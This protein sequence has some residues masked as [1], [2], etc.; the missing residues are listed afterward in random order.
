M[1]KKLDYPLYG[2]KGKMTYVPG[3]IHGKNWN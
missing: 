2:Q 1:K 3:K